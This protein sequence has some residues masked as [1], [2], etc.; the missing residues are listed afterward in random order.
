MSNHPRPKGFQ[1]KLYVVTK[2]DLGVRAPFVIG[3]FTCPSKARAACVGIGSFTIMH[4]DPNRVYPQG[5]LL[6]IE[7]IENLALGAHKVL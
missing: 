3:A 1:A 2:S 4:C 5:S 7:V 6:D